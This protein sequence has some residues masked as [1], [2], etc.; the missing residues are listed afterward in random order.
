MNRI[1]CIQTEE[2]LELC[3]DLSFSTGETKGGALD[4]ER[5]STTRSR[6]SWRIDIDLVS[7]KG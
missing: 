2:S 5:D 7:V 4:L 6:G 1:E 3:E